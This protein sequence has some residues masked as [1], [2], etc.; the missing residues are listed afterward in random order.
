VR[1][2]GSHPPTFLSSLTQ[3]TYPHMHTRALSFTLFLTTLSLFHALTLMHTTLCLSSYDTL[4]L[5][6]PE[7]HSLTQSV[8]FAF[9]LSLQYLEEAPSSPGRYRLY[10]GIIEHT[11]A[12][13]SFHEHG[14]LFETDG[15]VSEAPYRLLSEVERSLLDD[16]S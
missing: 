16:G 14:Y 2:F 7:A 13:G 10:D 4:S 9:S 3:Y 11:I 6:S 8:S 15:L 12:L 1:Y 5:L